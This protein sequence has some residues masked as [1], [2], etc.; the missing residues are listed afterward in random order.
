[1]FG[2]SG[3]PFTRRADLSDTSIVLPAAPTPAQVGLYLDALA[4]LSAQT[5]YPA[6]RFEL[7][8]APLLGDGFEKD[9]LVIGSSNDDSIFRPLE[10]NM[11]LK[12]SKGTFMAGEL[13]LP[14]VEWFSRSWV[15]RD[16]EKQKLSD[17]LSREN[18]PRFLIEQFQ[19]PFSKEH[20][21]VVLATKSETDE[22]AYFSR[23]VDEVRQGAIR[24]AIVLADDRQFNS[25]QLATRSYTLGSNRSVNAAY[26]WL[27]FHLW[28]VPVLLIGT[29]F[30]VARWWDSYLEN[31]AA[32]RLEVAL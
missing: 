7:T 30:L 24:G 25:F 8:D 2:A 20:T 5:G 15:G 19:S 28:L 4:F 32:K 14:R 17:I 11:I 16:T 13:N 12:P 6:I 9:L 26:S 18:A 31:Q 3:F 27:I 23:L 22:Q 10:S 1:V 21:A 29:A